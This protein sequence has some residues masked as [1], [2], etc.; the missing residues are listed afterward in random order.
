M[1][2]SISIF[3]S[4]CRDNYGTELNPVGVKFFH[5]KPNCGVEYNS[6]FNSPIEFGAETDSIIFSKSVAEKD[7]VGNPY[8][9]EIHDQYIIRYLDNININNLLIALKLR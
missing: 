1:D 4:A 7:L 2:L 9:A 6:Y 3:L 5:P 8:L